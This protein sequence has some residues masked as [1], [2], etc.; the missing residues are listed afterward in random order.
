MLNHWYTIR[1]LPSPSSL[2]AMYI[3]IP[4]T[5]YITMDTTP[6]TTDGHVRIEVVQFLTLKSRVHEE[7]N[8]LCPVSPLVCLCVV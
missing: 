5:M 3:T 4:L 6:L 2:M 7:F 8:Q 1:T